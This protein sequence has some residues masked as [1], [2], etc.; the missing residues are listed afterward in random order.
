VSKTIPERREERGESE[1]QL[2]MVRGVTPTAVAE[3]E[4]G[5]AEPRISR[6]RALA[7]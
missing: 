5:T 3:W 1:A 6:M 2:A 4:S 7:R